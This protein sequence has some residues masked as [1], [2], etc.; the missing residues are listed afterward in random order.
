ME[1]GFLPYGIL[2]GFESVNL[3]FRN[4][5]RSAF[6]IIGFIR[7]RSIRVLIRG[8]RLSRTVLELHQDSWGV[9]WNGHVPVSR[10][11]TPRPLSLDQSV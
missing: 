5:L 6:E 4:L 7:F 1:L 8:P 2:Y 3:Q 10:L 9:G 11:P